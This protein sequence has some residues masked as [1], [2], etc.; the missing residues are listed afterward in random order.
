MIVELL[1]VVDSIDVLSD[2]TVGKI[3]VVN[4]IDSAVFT[5]P[6]SP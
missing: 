3:V 2:E 4:N 5:L 6:C 1:T